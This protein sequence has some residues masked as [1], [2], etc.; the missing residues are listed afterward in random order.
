MMT[1]SEQAMAVLEQ[2][3]SLGKKM[4]ELQKDDS[5]KELFIEGY[6]AGTS[7]DISE[8]FCLLDERRLE[9]ATKDLYAVSF[10]HQFMTAI[11]DNGNNA[12]ES[13]RDL[14][15]TMQF[16]QQLGES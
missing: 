16:E 15:E 13:I 11:V 14:Q 9:R 12:V 5:F 4:Q 2:Q 8:G 3:V 7:K 6:V 1:E 10:F